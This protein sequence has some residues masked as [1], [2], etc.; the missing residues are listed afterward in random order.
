VA[1]QQ[2]DYFGRGGGVPRRVFLGGLGAAGLSALSGLAA[3]GDQGSQ[4]KDSGS[5]STRRRPGGNPEVCIFSKHLA[6]LD[7]DAMAETAAELGF[8]GVDITVRPRGHVLPER[9]VDDLPRVVEAIGRAGIKPSKIT[10]AIT[11]PRDSHTEPILKTMGALGIKYYRMGYYRFPKDK[12]IPKYLDDLRP[13][14]R[15][16][17]AMSAGYGVAAAYQNHSGYYLGSPVWDWWDLIR[18]I[19]P[20]SGGAGFEFDIGHVTA[21]GGYAGWLINSQLSEPW[22]KT[23]VVKDFKWQKLDDG[24]WRPDWCLL[25]QG[26][27]AAAPFLKLVKESGFSGPISTHFEYEIEA[28]NESEHNKLLLKSIRA[29]L[30]VLRGWLKDAGLG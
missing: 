6:W 21:E 23:L 9:V 24:T 28:A 3:F 22:W 15:D 4:S 2:T 14:V 18:D 25:G 16:L 1:S 26:M 11:D 27:I 29:D 8:D 13:M 10:T 17:A 7:Y 19:D 12:S 20:E 30:G 5:K